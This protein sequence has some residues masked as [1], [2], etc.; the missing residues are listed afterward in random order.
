MSNNLS[1]NPSDSVFDKTNLNIVFTY[2]GD[3]RQSIGY[4]EETNM[5][6]DLGTCSAINIKNVN[7]SK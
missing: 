3:Q 2:V 1:G 4:N 5:K 7:S 6:T